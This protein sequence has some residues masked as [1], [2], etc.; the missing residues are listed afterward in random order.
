MDQIINRNIDYERP[1]TIA[2]DIYWVGS[3]DPCS[4]LSDNPYLIIDGDEGILIDGGSRPDFPTVMMKIMQA[5]MPPGKISTLIYQ[6][7]DPDLC[8][9][10]TNLEQIIDN[11][12]LKIISHRSNNIFIRHYGVKSELQCIDAMNGHLTLQSGRILNFYKT[13]YAHSGGSFITHDTTTNTLFTSDIFGSFCREKDTYDLFK[14]IPE[15]CYPCTST[16]NVGSD[17]QC[18]RLGITCPVAQLIDFQ[19]HIMTSTKALRHA[20]G[21]IKNIG[22]SVIAPQ[23][24]FVIH[25]P[26]DFKFLYDRLAAA[27]DIGI[28]GILARDPAHEIH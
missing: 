26:G 14:I 3:A 10:I 13:P 23:H 11:P 18:G 8:G 27:E 6:H 9:S 5:G 21:V 28:D 22:A 4:N 24:G 7:Y 12:D 20:L 16:D 2:Q 15:A 19:S 25:R 1:V 17:G